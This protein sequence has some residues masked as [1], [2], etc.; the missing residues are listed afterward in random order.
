MNLR[1]QVVLHE[2]REERDDIGAAT[3]GHGL[4]AEV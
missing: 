2:V 1:R 3:L 4:K